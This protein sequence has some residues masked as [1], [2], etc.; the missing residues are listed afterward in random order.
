[1]QKYTDNQILQGIKDHD[2]AILKYLYKVYFP[3]VIDLIVKHHGREEEAKDIFQEAI[4]LLYGRIQN[5]ELKL[6]K[7]FQSYFMVMIKFIWFK[8]LERS[9]KNSNDEEFLENIIDDDEELLLKYEESKKYTLFLKHFNKLREDC[10]QILTL[11]FQKIPLKTIAD[12][13]GSKSENYV[14]K[15][16]NKCKDFLVTSIKSDPDYKKKYDT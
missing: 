11:F 14:K 12:K 8:K 4:I 5:G 10:K 16:K 9:P 3:G 7:S 13:I 6:K 2:S 15:R 1:V